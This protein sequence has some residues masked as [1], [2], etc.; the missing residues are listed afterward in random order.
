MLSVYNEWDRILYTLIVQKAS[1][2]SIPQ[3]QI[4][5]PKVQ[6]LIDIAEAQVEP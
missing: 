1:W 5:A 3:F 2:F 4:E 6:I